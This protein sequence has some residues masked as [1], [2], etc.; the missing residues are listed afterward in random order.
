SDPDK[1]NNMSTQEGDRSRQAG[2]LAK[3]K[4]VLF[5]GPQPA[6]AVEGAASMASVV[7]T[8]AQSAS[9]SSVDAE[10]LAALQSTVEER[11]GPGFAEFQ[12]QREALGEAIPEDAARARAA[13]R[14]LAKKGVSVSALLQELQ[15][16]LDALAA[17]GQ[18]W[19]E[20]VEARR[21]AQ[22]GEREN[23]EA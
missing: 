15:A 12:L 1:E 2:W 7:P 16:G 13:L 23:A 5:E 6:R 20:K 21:A 11:L 17:S 9:A 18:S 19:K 8:S 3:L 10:V 22:Q 4:D 14:V